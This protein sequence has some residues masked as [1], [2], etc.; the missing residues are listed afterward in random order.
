[1]NTA[2]YF[3]LRI[4]LYLL[5][6]LVTFPVPFL[7]LRLMDYLEAREQVRALRWIFAPV[8]LL[9]IFGLPFFTGKVAEHIAF[10]ER[11]FG[12]AT[13]LVF[14]DWR[15]RLT[16]LPVIGHWFEPRPDPRDDSEPDA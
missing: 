4:T 15:F 13:K 12:V 16:F 11:T 6:A 8:L 3:T 7:C 2:R 9:W 1:M 10:G 5:F 14:L